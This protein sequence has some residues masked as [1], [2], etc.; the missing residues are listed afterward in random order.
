MMVA[1]LATRHVPEDPASPMPAGG[2]VVAC[3]VFY[4]RRFDVPSQFGITS[5]DF[6]G[7]P[8]FHGL[9]H[10]MRGLHGD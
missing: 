2:Y 4:E 9:C 7:D 1:E 8:T 10:I 3:A 6:L 5:P